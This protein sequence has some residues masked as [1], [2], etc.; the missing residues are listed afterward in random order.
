M[1]FKTYFFL[2]NW[3]SRNTLTYASINISSRCSLLLDRTVH[4]W[5]T[6][7]AIFHNYFPSLISTIFSNGLAI[8]WRLHL[9]YEQNQ[10]KFII[11]RGLKLHHLYIYTL[12]K[13]TKVKASKIQIFIVFNNFYNKLQQYSNIVISCFLVAETKKKTET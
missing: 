13:Y 6:F 7:T 1:Q 8:I 9:S 12:Q 5:C 4:M 11:W 2:V 10:P 3:K